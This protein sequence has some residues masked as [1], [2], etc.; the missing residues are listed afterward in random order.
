METQT[1]LPESSVRVDSTEESLAHFD[2]EYSADPSKRAHIGEIHFEVLLPPVSNLKRLKKLQNSKESAANDAAFTRAFAALF[3]RLATWEP[4]TSGRGVKLVLSTRS[5]NDDIIRQ[6][7]ASGELHQVH[8]EFGPPIW[9]IRDEYRYIGL[10]PGGEDDGFWPLP[11]VACV[12]ELV[13]GPE[14]S[15]TIHPSALVALSCALTA[16]E[17]LDWRLA[18]PGRRLMADRREIRSALAHGLHHADFAPTLDDLTIYLWD[19]D[20]NNE[21]FEPGSF[22]EEDEESGMDDLS[23]AVRRICQLPSLRKLHLDGLW[24]LTPVTFGAHPSLPTLYC[25]SLEHLII[26]CARTTPDGEW[27]LTGDPELG[28][29]DDRYDGNCTVEDDPAAFDSDDSDTSD[30][31]PEFEWEWED[32]EIPGIWYRFRPETAYEALLQSFVDG[33]GCMPCLHIFDIHIGRNSRAPM[34]LVRHFPLRNEGLSEEGKVDHE[35]PY[36]EIYVWRNFDVSW[37]VPPGLVRALTGPNGDGRVKTDLKVTL[38]I[39]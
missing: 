9:E 11:Q 2:A 31:A 26:D 14:C 32:G 35:K 36:W 21:E 30:Y 37:K 4:R 6:L 38:D 39:L 23:L 22:K 15:S 13:F 34:R 24:I 1:D 12:S 29:G 16:V 33:A 3:S 25:P 19:E 10:S 28:I 18:M 27:M 7:V 8:N 5:L 20:P 17:K